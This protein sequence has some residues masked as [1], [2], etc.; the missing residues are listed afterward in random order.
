[1]NHVD[2]RDAGLE[3]RSWARG[4][5]GLA[6]AGAA[7][8]VA[9]AGCEGNDFGASATGATAEAELRISPSDTEKLARLTVQLPTG[10]C[11]PGGSCAR[12][13]AATP[14]LTLDGKAIAFGAEQRVLPGKH[15][16][17]VDQSSVELALAAAQTRTLILAVAHRKCLA[18]TLPEVSSTHFGQT[19]KVA[20]AECP[21]ALT[22]SRT[23]SEDPFL[24]GRTLT[25]FRGGSGLCSGSTYLQN[26]NLQNFLSA[27]CSD[28]GAYQVTGFRYSTDE[29]T[30][31]R[32]VDA[33]GPDLCR[34]IQSGNYA[35]FQGKPA[36]LLAD[37]DR[38][39]APGEY[40]HQV[41][42]AANP[43]TVSLGE[44][45]LVEIPISLPVVGQVPSTFK[46]TITFAD[47]RELPDLIGVEIVSSVSGERAYTLPASATR[48]LDLVAYR[49]LNAVY[50]LRVGGRTV[51]LDQTQANG[52]V[53]RRLDVDD[54]RVTREDGT[55]YVVKGTYE[56]YFGGTRVVMGSTNTGV[57]LL[58]GEYELVL[59][60][61]TAEGKKVQR[62]TLTL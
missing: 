60:Y 44:G 2:K 31:C 19:P 28:W 53:L 9:L 33:S 36:A 59:N 8:L 54:V 12:P 20:N 45:A 26:Y 35:D 7:G 34:R 29:G 40:A 58:P 42:G 6:L 57:D 30:V 49:N 25:W 32:P 50:T 37:A 55:G 15:V 62:Q 52:I 27:T 1:M 46:T 24:N 11:V 47:A 22:G 48:T 10:S 38:A 5:R 16:V 39:Y 56:V 23:L 14:R 13:L 43:T 21:S 18:E 4:L 3:L 61:T 41:A 51:T 17:A